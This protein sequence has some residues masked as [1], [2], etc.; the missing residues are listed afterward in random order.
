[1]NS[2]PQIRISYDSELPDEWHYIHDFLWGFGFRRKEKVI[3]LEDVARLL[4]DK[5]PEAE[6][7]FRF[8]RKNNFAGE[9][10]ELDEIYAQLQPLLEAELA[11][12]RKNYKPAKFDRISIP[13]VN[14]VFPH[15]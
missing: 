4:K 6:K 7:T 1:M 11:E 10:K 5:L 15:L 13:K 3:Y 8:L 9:C 2:E 12:R 14:R